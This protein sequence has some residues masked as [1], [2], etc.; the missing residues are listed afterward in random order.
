VAASVFG[1]GGAKRALGGAGAADDD[2]EGGGD[3]AEGD[4][5]APAP[6]YK[7]LYTLPEAPRVRNPHTQSSALSKFI[8]GCFRFSC[9][10]SLTRALPF[11]FALRAGDGRGG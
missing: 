11:P 2:E 7:P 5:A 10:F 4:A 1:G 9:S 3:G 8:P 6:E